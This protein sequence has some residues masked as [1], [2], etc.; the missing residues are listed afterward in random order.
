MFLNAHSQAFGSIFTTAWRERVE[1]EGVGVML[2]DDLGSLK[3]GR[4]TVGV[5]PQWGG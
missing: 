5:E 4:R 2:F 1:C 3:G